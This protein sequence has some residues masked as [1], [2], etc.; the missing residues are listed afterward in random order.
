ML[1]QKPQA[2]VLR[3]H[4]SLPFCPATTPFICVTFPV[5]SLLSASISSNLYLFLVSLS[6]MST[7]RVVNIM[8]VYM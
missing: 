5:A 4:P 1:L 7:G 6:F 2:S 8:Y 3:E